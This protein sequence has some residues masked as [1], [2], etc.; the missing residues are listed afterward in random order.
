MEEQL[1]SFE[2]AKLV[3]KGFVVENLLTL[4]ALLK[5]LHAGVIGVGDFELIDK[6]HQKIK[7]FLN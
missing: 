2:T 7:E 5:E 3:K 1:I 4:V 6:V